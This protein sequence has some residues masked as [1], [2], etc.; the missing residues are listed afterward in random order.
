MLLAAI[1]LALAAGAADAERAGTRRLRQPGLSAGRIVF[2]YAG[3]LWTASRS[4]GAPTRLTETPEAE[5]YPRFSPDGERLAFARNGEVY[6]MPAAG[7]AEK[8]LTSN[9]H[10]DRP[11][12]WTPDGKRVLIHSE[13]WRGA[14]TESPHLFTIP[15]DGGEAEPLPVPRA[16]HGSFSPDGQSIAYGPNVEIVLWQLWK[17]YR[18]GSL[19]YIALYD[20]ARQRYEELPRTQANDVWPMWGR[21]GIYFASDRGGVMNLYRY[22]RAAKKTGQLTRDRDWDVRHPSL[23]PDALIYEKGGWLY[24]LDLNTRAVRQVVI[25]VPVAANGAWMQ[26]LED[27]WRHYQEH[28]FRP[29]RSWARQKERYAGWLKWAAH[30]SDAEY[31]LREMLSEAGQSH[32]TLSGDPPDPAV[33]KQLAEERTRRYQDWLRANRERVKEATGG[34]IGY[35]HVP[36]VDTSGVAQFQKQW[37]EQRRSVAAMIIDAR[38]NSGGVKPLDV[39][40][41]IARA[42]RWLMFDRKGVVPPSVGPWLDGPKVMIANEQAGSGGDQLPMMFQQDKVGPV[43]GTR[44]VGALIGAGATYKVSG[45]WTMTVAEFG[46]YM[47]DQGKWSPENYGVAPDYVVELR[48]PALT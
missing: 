29:A 14:H 17:G 2:I 35:V 6:L 18:G 32:V 33:A 22:D 37:Q 31:V 43:V 24:T 13:R 23:G 34:R 10:Y 41:W 3:D 11:V 5:S 25:E 21:D 16:T 12:G 40:Q 4:G 42:P 38:N 28:A 20:M 7:G 26:S 45:G 46:F 19:G 47:T 30:K 27:A 39:H 36:N 8:R 44:T 1:F 48:P 15:V 9:P